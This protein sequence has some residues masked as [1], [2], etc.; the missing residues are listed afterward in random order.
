[1]SCEICG[2]EDLFSFCTNEKV[3]AICKLKYVGGLTATKE[4]IKKIRETF[5]IKD[6]EYLQQIK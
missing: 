5:G 2:R 1:M 6:G 4:S 3:C